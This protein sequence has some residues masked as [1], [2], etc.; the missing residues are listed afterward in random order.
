MG[1]NIS[2]EDFSSIRA[3]A[4]QIVSTLVPVRDALMQ[5]PPSSLDAKLKQRVI[6]LSPEL[7]IAFNKYDSESTATASSTTPS[8][9]IA[10]AAAGTAI[11]FTTKDGRVALPA[12]PQTLS[13]FVVHSLQ[14]CAGQFRTPV[15]APTASSS[16]SSSI[17]P[18]SDADSKQ[19]IASSN[20][21]AADKG[22]AFGM[23]VGRRVEPINEYLPYAYRADLMRVLANLLF[24][25]TAIA[26][27]L[28]S[29]DTVSAANADTKSAAATATTT[30]GGGI[31]TIMNHTYIDAHEPLLREWSVFALRNAIE[32][33]PDR[34]ADRV[35]QYQMSGISADTQEQLARIGMKVT[36]TTDTKSGKETV[37]VTNLPRPASDTAS[38]KK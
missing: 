34:V 30:M 12:L 7:T 19:S 14:W 31:E 5:S 15:A 26:D 23:G 3:L 22:G 18:S 9:A 20:S 2:D 8:K 16:S 35:R 33:S 13:E 11:A 10:T 24:H 32:A 1:G 29:A 27:S 36:P 6:S 38:A 25:Q 4:D 37:R 17:A 28:I 21:A